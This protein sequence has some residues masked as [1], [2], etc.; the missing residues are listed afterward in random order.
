[1]ANFFDDYN[2]QPIVQQE[3]TKETNIPE[4]ENETES[5]LK[6]E[7][8]YPEG[9]EDVGEYNTQ[10]IANSIEE[11]EQSQYTTFNNPNDVEVTIS[12]KKTPIVVLFGPPACGKTM[13]LV[14]LSRY[15]KN[16]LSGYQIKPVRSFRPDYDRNYKEMCDDFSQ[17]LSASVAAEANSRMNFM[18]VSVSRNAGEPI[19]QILEGPGELY[20]DP[21]KP[22]TRADATV[23]FNKI[24]SSPNRKVYVIILEPNWRNEQDRR[25]YV[26]RIRQLKKNMSPRDRIILLGNKVDKADEFIKSSGVVNVRG[27]INHMSDQYAGLFGIF[28]ET[29]PIISFFKPYDCDFVSFKSGTFCE[30]GSKN[31]RFTEDSDKYPKNLWKTILKRVGR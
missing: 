17:K 23:Y 9:K 30:D 15:L 2:E 25:N 3:E 28:K 10:G 5:E 20:F 11:T 29:R 12:D 16:C 21:K 31:M 8:N 22:N 19:C 14:R 7:M 1:M 13:T 26:E 18:L 27:F 6:P 4:T 24:T